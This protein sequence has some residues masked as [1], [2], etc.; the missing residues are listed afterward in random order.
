[1]GRTFG[2]RNVW[3]DLKLKIMDDMSFMDYVVTVRYDA[4]NHEIRELIGDY[5][6]IKNELINN[7]LNEREF[8]IKSINIII[9]ILNTN[10]GKE[11]EK[12]YGLKYLR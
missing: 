4:S 7:K 3:I 8:V 5:L 6:K 10:R 9:E 1:M 12:L 2:L 11:L